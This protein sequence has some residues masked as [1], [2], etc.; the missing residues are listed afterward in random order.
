[1]NNVTQ[2]QSPDQKAHSITL[3]PSDDTPELTWG[4]SGF[5]FA[6]D[7]DKCFTIKIVDDQDA[8]K[9]WETKQDA[10]LSEYLESHV[11]E[12]ISPETSALYK[13]FGAYIGNALHE[14]G[15]KQQPNIL[16]IGCGIG[17]NLPLYIRAL[18][19][20][21]NYFGLDAID[22][23]VRRDYPFICSRLETVNKVPEFKH[24][25]DTFIFG[26]SLDHFEDLD[27]VACVVKHLAAPGAKVVFWIGLHDM[28]LAASEEG[29]NR[30]GWVF[31]GE[32]LW[33]T[34]ARILGFSLWTFPRVAFAL[35][36]RLHRFKH[37]KK[38][39]NF[40]FWYFCERNLPEVLTKFGE[41]SDITYVP[42]GG[43]VFATCQVIS[44]DQSS[45]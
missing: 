27:D 38:I 35:L 7:D 20:D 28:A 39:D 15:E 23:H 13:L 37:R 29:A 8:S 4:Q 26:T 24:Q 17:R 44:E 30:F 1:M 22:V 21:V 10:A 31:S 40:H 16:D 25:F 43:S 12:Q 41:I 3:R 14:P 45:S 9:E 36:L 2:H 6:G 34:L 18:H 5:A 19:H 11:K 33:S 32:N 42:G